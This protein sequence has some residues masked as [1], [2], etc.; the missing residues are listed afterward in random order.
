MP[1]FSRAMQSKNGMGYSM[2]LEGE[3]V[4]SVKMSG[5]T[6][7]AV[8]CHVPEDTSMCSRFSFPLIGISMMCGIV[9][10]L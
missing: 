4:C 6:N 5:T 1:S 9:V 8:Q 10:A 7:P 3:A 2:N